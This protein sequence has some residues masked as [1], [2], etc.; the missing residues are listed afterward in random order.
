MVAQHATNG[1]QFG[2]ARRQ[3]TIQR[4]EDILGRLRQVKPI[5]INK[6]QALCPAHDDT[7]P[8]LTFSIGE[9]GTILLYCHAGCDIKDICSALGIEEKDLFPSEPTATAKNNRSSRKIIGE[10]NYINEEGKLIF[11]TVRFSPKGFAQRRPG[12][13]GEWV[14]DIKNVKRIL[15][16]LPE[17]LKADKENFVFVVEGEKDV[18]RLRSFS[19]TATTNPMGAGKWR[20]EYNEWL[21]DRKVVILPDNDQP[22]IKHA[23]DVAESLLGTAA[24][25]RIVKL[26][27]LPT[28]GDITDWLGTGGDITQLMLRVNEAKPLS[29]GQKSAAAEITTTDFAF[30]LTDAG[31]GE[32]FAVQ[33]GYKLRYCYTWERW[34]FFDG[35]RWND[36]V[37]EEIA[38][39]LAVETARGI[40]KEAENESNDNRRWEILKWSHKSESGYMRSAMLASAHHVKPIPAYADEFDTNPWLLN[41]LNGS[42]DLKTGRLQPHNPVDMITKLAPVRYDPKGEC[43]LWFDCLNTWMDGN[44]EKIDYLQRLGGYC[45]TGD[46]AAR[47][48]PIFYGSG[49]NGKSVFCNTL[50]G[51]MGDYGIIAPQDF[52]AEKHTEEHPTEIADLLGARLVIAQETRAGMRLRTS[53]VKS[54]TGERRLKARFMRQNYFE[55]PITHKIILTTNSKPIIEDMSDAIWDRTALVDWPV[56][57]PD[58]EV[59]IHLLDKLDAER[60]GLLNWLLEGCRKLQ[61]EN[62]KLTP[63]ESIKTA[64]QIYRDESDPL[65]DFIAECCI[66]EPNTV[67]RVRDLRKAYDAWVDRNNVRFILSPRRFNEILTGLGPKRIP[68]WQ[69]GK[70]YK[71]WQGITLRSE[72]DSALPVLPQSGVKQL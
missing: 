48:F 34:L 20:K 28:G 52:L 63:P 68:I 18:D 4:I 14:W 9:N 11:Q 26:D 17:L 8:S 59:D 49:K 38:G 33:H 58:D 39:N 51:L 22:G 13:N 35:Q 32:R 12:E 29:K 3:T 40:I 56:R 50:I 1:F 69:N 72:I 57:I 43:S 46:V 2:T 6:W 16:Q 61:A 53:L 54:M 44:A 27:N 24:E 65:T 21:R 45:L 67:T 70:D 41:V 25:V 37:A 31:N 36:K 19:L 10:Y 60:P 66:I 55:F 47:I 42:I 5:A 64:T 15:Y 7:V 30:H 71:C 62:Y 23:Q